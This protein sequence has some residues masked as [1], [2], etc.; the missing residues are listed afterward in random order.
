MILWDFYATFVKMHE[1]QAS[2]HTW[3]MMLFGSA[4]WSCEHERQKCRFITSIHEYAPYWKFRL[5]YYPLWIHA[6][7]ILCGSHPFGIHYSLLCFENSMF[8]RF[9]TSCRS[10]ISCKN[11]FYTSLSC[12]EIPWWYP[13]LY[14]WKHCIFNFEWHLEPRNDSYYWMESYARKLHCVINQQAQ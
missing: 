12:H 7:S 6:T 8:P 2:V 4:Q 3:K 1:L 10:G 14:D 9:N 13:K 5:V 11:L